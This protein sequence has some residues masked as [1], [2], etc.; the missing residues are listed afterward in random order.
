MLLSNVARDASDA[1]PV[2]SAGNTRPYPLRSACNVAIGFG[3][4]LPVGESDVDDMG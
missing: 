4:P 2:S 3:S 1:L